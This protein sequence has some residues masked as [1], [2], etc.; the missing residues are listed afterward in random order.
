MSESITD[1]INNNLKAIYN[2]DDDELYKEF[3][4]D[5]DGT[6]PA[7]IT[8]PT[9]I[10]IGVIASQIE[11]LRLLSISLSNQLYIDRATGQFLKYELEQ[12]FASLQLID[13]TEAEWITRTT[14]FI[15]QPRC[16]KVALI[17]A[18]TP[19]FITP[20]AISNSSTVLCEIDIIVYDI[21]DIDPQIILNL[22]DS[23]VA[24]GITYTISYGG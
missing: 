8:I 3:V 2:I 4:C 6:I 17:T 24:A 7:T 11:Y 16:S 5:K 18:L 1:R 10:D 20:P 22:I 21:P 14:N 15:L 23:Y 13:E 9:D 19:Y 12:F